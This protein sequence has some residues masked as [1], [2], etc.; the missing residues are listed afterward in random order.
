MTTLYVWKDG[1]VTTKELPNRGP[2]DH[3]FQ[4]R[5]PVSELAR[6]ATEYQWDLKT[7]RLCLAF[8]ARALCGCKS[9]TDNRTQYPDSLPDSIGLTP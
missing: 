5:I 3:T 4:E 8:E 9:C 7:Q 6:M 2:P 1:V